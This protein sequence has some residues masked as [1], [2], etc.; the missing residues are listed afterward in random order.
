MVSAIATPSR[1]ALSAAG[2][3]VVASDR[4]SPRSPGDATQAK[5]AIAENPLREAERIAASV[6]AP[7]RLVAR[8]T[9]RTWIRVRTEDGASSEENVPAAQVREW[10]SNGRLVVSIGNAGGVKLELNGRT[11]PALGAKGD[12]IPKLVLPP[13]T[14]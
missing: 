9:D 8:T 5:D 11:L 10:V 1:P 3:P 14:P 13:Q 12:V 4:A 2:T 6:R 7:Y